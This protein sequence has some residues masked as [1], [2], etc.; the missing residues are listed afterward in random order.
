MA[1]FA[2]LAEQANP[3]FERINFRR[4]GKFVDKTFHRKPAARLL[5]RPPPHHGYARLGRRI[6]DAE[7]AHGVG[8]P[9]SATNFRFFRLRI[10]PPEYRDRCR[11]DPVA[12]SHNLA[13]VVE[14]S[15]HAVV[16]RLAV[17]I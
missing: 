17:E 5:D 1:D 4:R 14:R 11:G 12:P 13:L 2:W 3:V 15:R 7:A 6:L 8:R 9:K 10:G 16:K